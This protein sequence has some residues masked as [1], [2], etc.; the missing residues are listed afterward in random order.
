MTV[1]LQNEEPAPRHRVLADALDGRDN[2]VGLLRLVLAAMV[3]VSHTYYLGYGT[4]DPLAGW[5]RGRLNLGD[6]AVAGFFVLSGMLVSAS[7]QR[8]RSTPRYLWHRFLRIMPAFWACLILTAF[9]MAPFV[10]WREKGA[11][12]GLWEVPGEKPVTFVA[13]NA[14]LEIHQYGIAGMLRT[15]NFQHGI[16]AGY[17]NGSIWTL[18]YEAKCYLLV[19][20]LGLAGLLR[21]RHWMVAVAVVWYIALRNTE[22]S[23]PGDPGANLWLGLWDIRLAALGF[24]FLAGIL[25]QLYAPHIRLRGDL[26]LLA[27][28]GVLLVPHFG[29][30]PL[31]GMAS[32]TYLLC[33]LLARLPGRTVGVRQDFSY[34]VYL[35]GV[36]VQQLLVMAGATSL[37]A[38][39]F[40]TLSL[41]GAFV[42]A[43]PSW[44]AV[45]RPAMLLKNLRRKREGE[46][47][48]PPD[49][50]AETP[51]VSARE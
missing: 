32:L 8:L 28:A 23:V 46:P 31:L 39:G 30:E 49:P 20:V 5:A 50:A 15:E 47:V 41:A 9:V 4:P 36:P 51:M 11:L 45:E 16:F 44:Y 3:I 17:F 22:P 7:W 2:A 18:I 29:W 27:L 43:V 34:G 1:P 24:A 26:A 38:F 13:H 25:A 19:I 40:T 12:G 6:L 21:R 42:C 35:Y 37:G 10:W 33:W 14:T 48:P